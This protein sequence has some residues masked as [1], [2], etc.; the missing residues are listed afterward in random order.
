MSHL[1]HSIVCWLALQLL[2]QQ[3]FEKRC[4]ESDDGHCGAQKGVQKQFEFI[5]SMATRRASGSERE[6][7]AIGRAFD[8]AKKKIF[9][10]L[11]VFTFVHVCIVVDAL[12]LS[13]FFF[14]FLFFV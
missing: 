7:V 10:L 13:L 3:K 2:N 6:L 11:L 4:V 14:L 12:A 9:F 5:C 1:N 8:P